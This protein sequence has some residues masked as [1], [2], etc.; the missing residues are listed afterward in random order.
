M[1][2]ITV[3]SAIDLKR[4]SDES[5]VMNIDIKTYSQLGV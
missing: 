2:I 3:I 5:L 1:K 4:N